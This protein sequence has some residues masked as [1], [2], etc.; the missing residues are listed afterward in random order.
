MKGNENEKKYMEWCHCYKNNPSVQSIGN[1]NEDGRCK[2]DVDGNH[3]E[4]NHNDCFEDSDLDI[5]GNIRR[6]NHR[7]KEEMGKF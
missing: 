6:E 5:D 3:E 4:E 7:T 2:V 1:E